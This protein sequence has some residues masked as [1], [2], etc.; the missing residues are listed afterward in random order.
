[1]GGNLR[2]KNY[3]RLKILSENPTKKIKLARKTN[4]GRDKR[5]IYVTIN[6]TNESNRNKESRGR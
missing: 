1:M 3:G 6:I 5:L 2:L 4:T